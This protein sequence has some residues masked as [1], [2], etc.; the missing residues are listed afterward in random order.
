MKKIYLLSGILVLTAMSSLAFFNGDEWREKVDPLVFERFEAKDLVEFIVYL[1]SQADVSNA[2]NFQTK[3]ERGQYVFGQLKSHAE[4]T[5]KDLIRILENNGSEFRSFFVVNSI[6]VKGDR[7]ILQQLAERAEVKNIQDNTTF[8]VPDV[9]I[10]DALQS[11]GPDAIEWGI[12][13]IQADLVWDLGITGEGVIIGGQDTGY[14]WDHPALM[15]KYKGY[16]SGNVDHNYHWHDAIHEINPLHNDSIIQASNNPCGLDV[17]YPC[18]DHNHGTHTMGTM[19]GADGDNQIG[20]APT[21]RWIACRNMERGY[22]TPSTYIE[23]FEWFLAPTDLSNQNPDP[24]KAPHVIANSWSCPELEG[25]NPSNFG[26]MQTAVD[27]LK[28]SGVVV[29]V[30]AGNSGS[31]GC[32]SIST[33]AAIFENSFTIG[34]SAEND[35]ITGF[36]SRGPVAVDGSFRMKPNVVA[37]GRNVRSCIRDG[38]YATYNGTSMAGPH[39]AGAVALIIAANP[40][41]AGQV[42]VIETILEQTAV[43][44][45]TDQECGNTPGTNVPNNTYGY[46]RINALAAVQEALALLN[47]NNPGNL[48]PQVSFYPNPFSKALIMKMTNWSGN[49]TLSIFDAAGRLVHLEEWEA[50]NERLRILDLNN[51]QSGVFFYRI[52]NGEEEFSGKV[53]KN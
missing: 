15:S 31:Q 49:T 34:A 38:Q 29:V 12:Q 39:A 14:E 46:G 36:S 53:V 18:D 5:Q 8:K 47:T 16:D 41:L 28:A 48:E 25:C 33:P 44:K 10:G 27:N 6:W 9:N 40:A 26:L 17:P 21:A 19:V 32:E 20:V 7:E 13:M 42:E 3:E 50:Q 30:S 45:Q 35:T 43:P 24:G 23:C 2:H 4:Q 52:E 1:E 22:G 37:P 11:R 51:L